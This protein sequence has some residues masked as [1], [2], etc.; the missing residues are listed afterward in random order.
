MVYSH[1]GLVP[2]QEPG[3]CQLIHDISFPRAKSVNSH[4]LPEFTTLTFQILDDCAEQLV[5]LGKGAFIAKA[6]L[7]DAF[8]IIP[9]SPLVYR[10]LGFKCQGLNYFDRC[11]PMGCSNSC[12]TV[13]LLS[14]ALQWISQH[15][16]QVSSISHILDDFIFFSK[17]QSECNF[18]L[19]R[20]LEPSR[21]VNLPIKQSKTALPYTTVTLHSIEVGTFNQTLTLP[22]N[23]VASLRQKLIGMGKRKKT[24]L[25]EIQSL[26]C[27][28]NF[29]CRPIA[30][31]RATPHWS[32]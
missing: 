22:M 5:V 12:Q 30:P 2:K 4:I 31:G 18:N 3:E 13:E 20:F 6:D 14:Q 11:F 16:F 32:D 19:S 21:M 26:I 9:V 15:K 29:V 8:R 24:T 25:K 27:S 17:T 23:N 28:L 1:L 7:Q 10:L